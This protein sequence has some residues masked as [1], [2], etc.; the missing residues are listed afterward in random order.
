M[1]WEHRGVSWNATHGSVGWYV[2]PF[3]V[4]AA[5]YATYLLTVPFPGNYAGLYLEMAQQ[6]HQHGYQLPARVPHYTR[7]GLPF[8]YPPLGPYLV[9]VLHGATGLSYLTLARYL[10]GVV[11]L[12]YLV[13][14][15][16]VG[17]ELTDSARKAGLATA[18]VAFSPA[19]FGW[20][21]S[22]GGVVRAPAF[23]FT[24]AGVYTGLKLF[25][26]PRRRW[27]L[28]SAA[29]FGCTVLT[30]PVNTVFFGVSYVTFFLY[31]D[32]TP[33]GLVRGATVAAGGFALAFPWLWQVSQV[34]GIDVFTNAAG[35]RG[36]I[37]PGVLVSGAQFLS[38]FR[39]ELL[40]LWRA[41][42]VVGLVS[43]VGRARYFLPVWFGAVLLTIPRPR[44]LM[45]VGAFAAAHFV[46]DDVLAA[47]GDATVPFEIPRSYLS[48]A[49]VG[50]LVGF[51]LV[52]GVLFTAGYPVLGPSDTSTTSDVTSADR[53]AIS[54]VERNTA[55]DASFV[56]TGGP[57][58][59]FPF[60]ADR[61]L[62]VSPLGA[63]W[64]GEERYQDHLRKYGELSNC[65]YAACFART[66]RTESVETDY[67]YVS[68]GD[69]DELTWRLLREGFRDSAAFEVAYE[70]DGVVVV[71]TTAALSR[72]A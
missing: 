50:L 57:Y 19:V 55:P 70:N 64:L 53:R 34:H 23:L 24:V 47:V 54:W 28:L 14:T 25:T 58:E 65:E 27:L 20:H 26:A 31:F 66:L 45:F 61:T 71:R 15:L 40:P 1:E 46:V 69:R 16:F 62:V 21:L 18:V 7:G 41:L 52:G 43:L 29:L 11:T 44:F 2:A 68:R 6:I 35:T 51:G 39:T 38:D 17:L 5:V 10:P 30:H 13:P 36:G 60:M 22:A 56:V 8:A 4:G 3:L 67:V 59:W 9:A 32:R 42:A 37:F 72:P 48:A 49:A 63:E 12:L 33:A